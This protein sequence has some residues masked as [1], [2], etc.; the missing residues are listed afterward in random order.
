MIAAN[1]C[2]YE[3]LTRGKC[4]VTINQEYKSRS[5]V[6]W[7]LLYTW[8]LKCVWNYMGRGQ[9]YIN[10]TKLA[11]YND[12]G[13]KHKAFPLLFLSISIKFCSFNELF[14][15][16]RCGCNSNQIHPV[17]VISWK[18]RVQNPQLSLM[19]PFLHAIVSQPLTV[20]I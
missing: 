17:D 12:Y 20:F 3:S 19:P 16:E 14:N 13:W 6:L 5:N 10:T 7:F 2:S 8:G 1:A 9:L 18:F 15:P 11:K 4:C